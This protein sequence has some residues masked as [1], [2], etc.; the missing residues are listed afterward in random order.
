MKIA[1]E[2]YRF[3]LV[4]ALLAV[5]AFVWGLEWVGVGLSLLALVFLGFF[6]DP[7][8]VP[9]AGDGLIVSP[10]D[11]KIVG[12]QKGGKEGLPGE[13]GTRV[14]IFLSPLDVHVNRAPVK[15]SVESVRYREGKF[16]A[17]YREKASQDNEQNALSIVD[18]R[19]RKLGVVQIAGAVAR[20]IVCYVR[21]GDSLE[22]GQRFGM[23]MFGSRVDLFLPEDSHV[24]V[25]E[26]QH[27]R[28]GVT[29]I[30]RFS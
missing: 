17:A 23:I 13:A 25:A 7:E 24:E 2:G 20:R 30:G 4:A 29:I 6:R 10:A 28:G 3:V 22:Q 5:L 21:K 15:G 14:S 1:R 27:V 26:G 12:I 8:R 16:F 9:P 18:N 19:G 11:G